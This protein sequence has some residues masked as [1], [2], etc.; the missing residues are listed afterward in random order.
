MALHFPDVGAVF[1]TDFDLTPFGPWYG[2]PESDPGS[3]FS[4]NSPVSWRSSTNETSAS[5]RYDNSMKK[6]SFV[7]GP[8]ITRTSSTAIRGFGSWARSWFVSTLCAW[9]PCT[10]NCR[11]GPRL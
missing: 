6:R 9:A 5:K 10:P 3:N 8:S 7:P 4:P 11:P 1:V 2:Q